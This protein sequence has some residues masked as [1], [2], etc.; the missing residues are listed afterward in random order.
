M[1]ID[2][3]DIFDFDMMILVNLKVDYQ[4]VVMVEEVSFSGGF[5]EK[6][7]CYYGNSVMCVLNFGVVKC[8]ND[9]EIINEL[10]Y[11]FKLIF[12]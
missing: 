2:F 5:G 4:L 1:F 11:E 6:V 3:W 8:F 10:W 9:C 12:D 7:S